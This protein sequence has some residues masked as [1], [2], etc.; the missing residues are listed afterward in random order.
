MS[1]NVELGPA[2]RKWHTPRLLLLAHAD[3]A[4]GKEACLRESTTEFGSYGMLKS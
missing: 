2:P 3:V 1:P 4:E